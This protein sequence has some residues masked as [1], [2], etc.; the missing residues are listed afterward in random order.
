MKFLYNNNRIQI[1]RIMIKQITGFLNRKNVR[2]IIYSLI[3]VILNLNLMFLKGKKKDKNKKRMTIIIVLHLLVLI[4]RWI[5]NKIYKNNRKKRKM[6][7]INTKVPTLKKKYNPNL[8]L[9]RKPMNKFRQKMK[10]R[11][12]K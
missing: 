3:V 7:Q 1:N 10:K 9:H 2:L 5:L 6:I 8:D 4:V 11:L 12:K